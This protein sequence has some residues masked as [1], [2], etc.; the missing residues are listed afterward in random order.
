MG[1][2]PGRLGQQ[3]HRA[4]VL[5][6]ECEMT[7][8][9]ADFYTGAMSGSDKNGWHMIAVD[10]ETRSKAN[11]RAHDIVARRY[12]VLVSGSTPKV[13]PASDTLAALIESQ[14]TCVI[15]RGDDY[16]IFAFPGR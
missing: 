16:A 5:L 15:A 12:G 3:G 8:F 6:R 4:F 14:D 2:E 11:S 9:T 1:C 10:G 7:A 13:K